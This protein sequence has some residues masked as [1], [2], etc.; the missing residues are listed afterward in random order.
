M[1]LIARGDPSQAKAAL[2]P[3]VE[4]LREGY[5]IAISPEGTRS[6]TPA[7]GRF[8]KGAFHMAMQGGVPIVAVVIRNA[9]ELWWRGSKVMRS[10]TVDVHV[11]EPISVQDWTRDTLSDRI[12]EVRELFV[13]TLEDWPPSE[14][15]GAPP[16]EA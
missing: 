15:W 7:V 13:R 3:V 10:G 6:A 1:A 12:A 11:H 9:G 2:G 4:R 14:A 5:S 16:S 8:K